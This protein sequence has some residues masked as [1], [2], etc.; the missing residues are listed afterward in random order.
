MQ[1]CWIGF[2]PVVIA[3]VILVPSLLMAFDIAPYSP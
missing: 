2:L 1:M 3:L